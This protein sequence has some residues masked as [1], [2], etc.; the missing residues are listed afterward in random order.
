MHVSRSG[1]YSCKNRCKPKR[2]QDRELQIPKVKELH[3]ISRGTY[4][5]RYVAVELE[6]AAGLSCGQ[7]KAGTL[8]KLSEVQVT[9]KIHKK[10]KA[11]TNRKQ[12]PSTIQYV[13]F[14]SLHLIT[15]P[16]SSEFYDFGKILV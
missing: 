9:V 15:V 8:M 6:K 13:D 4:G 12:S 14:N 5:K 2:D 3:K 11:T 1:F 16:F 10:F 7:Q